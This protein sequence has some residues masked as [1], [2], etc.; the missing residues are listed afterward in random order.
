MGKDVYVE[1]EEEEIIIMRGGKMGGKWG[2]V[3][4]SGVMRVMGEIG[5]FV[6]GESGEMGVVDKMFRGVGGREKI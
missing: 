3:G 2:L 4:E 6:G 1:R 5:W